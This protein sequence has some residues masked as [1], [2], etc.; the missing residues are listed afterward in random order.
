MKKN[1]ILISLVCLSLLLAA[2]RAVQG[3]STSAVAGTSA[4]SDTSGSKW[5]Q[6]ALGT[7]MLDEKNLPVDAKQA[8]ELLPLWKAARSLNRGETTA[9]AEISGLMKQIQGTLT[10]DQLKAIQTMDLSPQNLPASIQQLSLQTGF[11]GQ[12]PGN[13]GTP[14]ASSSM[15]AGA[16]GPPGD[17]SG[18]PGEGGPPPGQTSQVASG[19][20]STSL[21]VSTDLL[22]EVI[23]Y[24]QAKQ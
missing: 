12:P 19:G 3:S 20:E 11:I 17:F 16:G 13:M 22:D 9:A 15:A 23:K 24:L 6:L 5:M 10:S 4:L 1:A 14:S 2:C 18:I 21:G 7:L 8:A